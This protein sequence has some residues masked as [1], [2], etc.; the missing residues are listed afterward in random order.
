VQLRHLTHTDLSQSNAI[1]F[2]RAGCCARVCLRL[3]FSVVELI[4][5]DCGYG[6]CE[7]FVRHNIYLP[8]AQQDPVASGIGLGLSL[9]ERNVDSLGG[10]VDIETDQASGT[11]A[12]ISVQ[13]SD[14]VMEVDSHFE[15]DSK[16]QIAVGVIPP[17]PKR[18]KDSL[19]VMHACFY[20]PSTWL[21][22]YDRRDERSINLLFDSLSST[23]GEWYQPVLSLWQ[24]QKKR[25]VPDLISISQRNLAEFKEEC[26]GEFA[27]VKKVVICATIGNNSLQ[28]QERMRQASAFADALIIGAVLL[29]KLWEVVT[30]YFPQILQ[31]EASADDQ[32]RKNKSDD[33]RFKSLGSTEPKEAVR[34]QKGVYDRSSRHMLPEP[35]LENEQSSHIDSDRRFSDDESIGQV[36]AVGSKID[37]EGDVKAAA[38]ATPGGEDVAHRFTRTLSAPMIDASKAI[39]RRHSTIPMLQGLAQ[40]HLLLVDD[41]N[42]NLKMLGMFVGKCG[43]PV[44]QSTSVSGGQEAIEVFKPFKGRSHIH[45][46]GIWL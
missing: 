22:R 18:S 8:F 3:S 33:I 43:I 46:R 29:S 7:D 17:L 30:S 38:N 20:A 39:F 16:S 5:S 44:A 37:E 23:L 24:Q 26:G 19:P 28:D 11:T 31:P 21:R 41:N 40:P 1:R 36:T 13:T 15:A 32:T 2:T 9:V 27:N 42:I 34:E 14:L 4:V 10:T 6:M 12:T 35:D 25:A 45:T